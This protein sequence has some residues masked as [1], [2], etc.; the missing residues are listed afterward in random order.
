MKLKIYWKLAVIWFL[1]QAATSQTE[2]AENLLKHM[3]NLL[4]QYAKLAISYGNYRISKFV[5]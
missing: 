2:S 1:E 3:D 5:N 4:L